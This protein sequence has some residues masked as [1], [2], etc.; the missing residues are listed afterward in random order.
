MV[1]FIC[2]N[3]VFFD[4][5]IIYQIA[6]VMMF[7]RNMFGSRWWIFGFFNY[8]VALVVLKKLQVNVGYVMIALQATFKSDRN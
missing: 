3:E 2:V 7:N 4:N 5:T 8:N 1:L 6:K